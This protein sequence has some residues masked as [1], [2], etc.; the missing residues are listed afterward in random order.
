MIGEAITIL[1]IIVFGTVFFLA[2][3]ILLGNILFY[4][5]DGGTGYREEVDKKRAE[6]IREHGDKRTKYEKM[7][8]HALSEMYKDECTITLDELKEERENDI[9]INASFPGNRK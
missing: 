7:M 6:R 1:L 2:F 8:S 5:N 3:A 9:R 4:Y